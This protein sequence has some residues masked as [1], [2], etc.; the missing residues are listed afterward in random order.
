MQADEPH[1]ETPGKALETLVQRVKANRIA[2]NW[3]QA[4]MA[5]RA[6]LSLG[7]Y[8]NFERGFGINLANLL[9]LLGVLG[10][11]TQFANMIPSPQAEVTGTALL[12]HTGPRQRVRVGKGQCR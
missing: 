8:Q 7:T 1:V 6:G 11:L 9:R 2:R 10:Y 12:T 3:T 4:E 5:R